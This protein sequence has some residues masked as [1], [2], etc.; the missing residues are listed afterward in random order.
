MATIEESGF[1][2]GEAV[3]NEAA[4]AYRVAL[5]R[6]LLAVYA[7]G[8]LAHGGFS[9]LVSDI[10]LCLILADPVQDSDPDTVQAVADAVRTGGSELHQRLSVFWGTSSTLRGRAA[11]GRFPPLDRLDLLEH[12]RL[13]T[14]QD[15]RTG[16]QRPD[17]DELL[18][19]GAEFALDFLGPGRGAAGPAAQ[20]LGSLRPGGQGAIDDVRRPER[21]VPRGAR[22]LTKAVM[23]PV[24]FLYT[25]ATGRLGTNEAAVEYHLADEKAPA[26]EL[27]AAALTW[28]TVPPEDTHAATE[29]LQR[30]LMPLYLHYIDDHIARLEALGEAALAGA[31]ENWRRLLTD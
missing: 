26:G 12:G 31:F 24:R 17:R 10:D 6:R 7:L 21:L 2:E 30:E 1:A 27:V 22:P 28:R 3:L 19:T 14:G 25:A 29:L 15:V 18:V 8:S 9:P 20:G 16:L 11:G 23:F 13:L 4:A 5:G